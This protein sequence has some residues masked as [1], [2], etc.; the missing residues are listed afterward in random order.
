M[1]SHFFRMNTRSFKYSHTIGFGANTPG[2]GMRFPID[3]ALRDGVV[4]VVNRSFEEEFLPLGA[5]RV[6]MV[7]ENEEW[8]GDIGSY[9][10]A[11]GQFVWATA[12]AL[13]SQGLVY[14]SDEWLQRI[15]I[16]QKDGRFLG[17][18][19]APG[20]G[21][22]EFNRPSGM[23]FDKDD[24]LYVVD[25]FNHRVQ[26][27]SK[28]GK[29]LDK[30]G[31]QGSGDGQLNMPWGI[32]IDERGDIWIADWGNSRIQK[33]APDG[34]SLAR[35][36]SH[37]DLPGQFNHPTG[38]CVDK[39]GDIYVADWY[40]NRVE[41][42]TPTFKY[43]TSLVGDATFSKWGGEKVRSNPPHVQ[44][45]NLIKDMTPFKRFRWPVAVKVDDKGTVFV[46]DTCADRV[47]IYQKQLV[48]EGTF[49]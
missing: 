10:Q 21:D 34:R 8:L 19:G 9:G 23:A 43:I 13:D 35:F 25:G 16:F 28:E 38:V 26:V 39:D 12:I 24:N 47:Q 27:F 4:Y 15:S 2:Q 32:F 14:V 46:A 33:F 11:D 31:S 36:G 1:S 20:S 3:L 18:W 44:M 29:L 17:K 40:N 30:F 7:N 48:P 5:I 6:C 41:I 42:F 22:G 45:F 37:G 49:A